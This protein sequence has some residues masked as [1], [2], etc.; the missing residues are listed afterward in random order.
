M[1]KFFLDRIEDASGV[2]G[3]GRVAEG[4]IFSNGKCALCWLTE[5]SSVAM[6]ETLDDLMQVHGHGGKTRIVVESPTKPDMP[7]VIEQQDGGYLATTPWLAGCIAEGDAP[8]EALHDFIKAFN[9]LI[10]CYRKENKRVPWRK[11]RQKPRKF[12][13]TA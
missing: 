13:K 2:S 6:Y 3:I 7:V 8:M 9:A 11:G 4:I 1:F 5:T 10:G 12:S